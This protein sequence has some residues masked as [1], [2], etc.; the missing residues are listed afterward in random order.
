MS[1]PENI[2]YLVRCSNIPFT[3]KLLYNYKYPSVWPSIRIK[4]KGNFLGPY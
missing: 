3:I 2:G 4:G 1:I